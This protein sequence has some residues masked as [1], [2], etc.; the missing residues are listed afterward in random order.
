MYI[1]DSFATIAGWRDHGAIVHY[2]AVPGQDYTLSGDGVLLLDSGRITDLVRQISPGHFIFL[3]RA[4]LLMLKLSEK[5]VSFWRR[6]V[7]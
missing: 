2:R 5:P 3:S 4:S 6:I 1:C 7:S